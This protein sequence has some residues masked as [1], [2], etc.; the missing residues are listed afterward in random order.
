MGKDRRR[1][2]EKG[3]GAENE[4]NYWH[5]NPNSDEE[6]LAKSTQG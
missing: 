4:L 6:K 3:G 2:E 1:D 5:F